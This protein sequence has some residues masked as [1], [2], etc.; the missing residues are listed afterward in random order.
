MASFLSDHAFRKVLLSAVA[1]LGLSAPAHADDAKALLKAMSD[2]MAAQKSISFDYQS[3]VET[4]TPDFEKIQFVSSGTTTIERPDKARVTRRGGI[5]DL[6]MSFDGKVLT[7]HGKNLDAYAKIDAKGTLDDLFDK[8]TEADVGAPGSDLFSADAYGILTQEV[9][10]AKHISSAVVDGVDCEYLT[11][12]TPEVD[13]QVWVQS[14]SKPIP[15]RYVVTMKHVA[16]APQYT[17]QITNFKEGAEAAKASFNIEIPKD[18]KEVELNQIE[19]FNELPG[20][21]KDGANPQ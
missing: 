4:V 5:A 19:N 14:G 6:D 15:C 18:A 12:R 11:F 9:T 21:A 17:L 13:W 10:E 16:Q 3:T 7:I 20:P 2:Y 8:L 1:T